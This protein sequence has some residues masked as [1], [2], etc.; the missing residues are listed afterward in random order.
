[1]YVVVTR[2]KSHFVSNNNLLLRGARGILLVLS[3]GSTKQFHVSDTRLIKPITNSSCAG[4]FPAR[5]IS[6]NLGR[7]YGRRKLRPRKQPTR[8]VGARPQEFRARRI[9]GRHRPYKVHPPRPLLSKRRNLRFRGTTFFLITEPPDDSLPN[10]VPV[11]AFLGAT[12]SGRCC[13]PM[14]D[15]RPFDRQPVRRRSA[16]KRTCTRKAAGC[17]VFIFLF[18]DDGF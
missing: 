5:P 13:S 15:R 16:C 10:G 7:Y 4:T 8:P 12:T 9:Y 6:C 18:R 17:S 1:V 2:E 14:N 3:Y 11:T